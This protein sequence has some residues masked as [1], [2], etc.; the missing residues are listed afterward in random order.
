MESVSTTAEELF[1]Y[2]L[3]RPSESPSLCVLGHRRYSPCHTVS[4]TP[5]SG[6]SIQ[7][8]LQQENVF[9][10]IKERSRGLRDG[11]SSS[12]EDDNNGEDKTGIYSSFVAHHHSICWYRSP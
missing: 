7:E 2:F 3:A 1:Q 12:D 9:F 11:S 6:I 4:T 8:T 5:C 10:E